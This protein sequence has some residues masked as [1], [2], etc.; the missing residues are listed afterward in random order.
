VSDNV[1]T[2]DWTGLDASIFEMSAQTISSI[3]RLAQYSVSEGCGNT[4]RVVAHGS[5]VSGLLERAQLVIETSKHSATLLVE[6]IETLKLR[7]ADGRIDLGRSKIESR[8]NEQ[9]P[10]IDTR[11]AW[12]GFIRE[13]RIANPPLA[14]ECPQ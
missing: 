11:L 7:K 12:Y 4:A 13:A 3:T 8:R 1:P 10:R 14:A 6:S 5:E 2:K 9:L